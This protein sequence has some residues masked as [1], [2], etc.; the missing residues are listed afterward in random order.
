MIQFLVCESTETHLL[1]KELSQQS[2][3]VFIGSSF[4]RMVRM[5]EV[6]CYVGPP[7]NTSME[8]K[9]SPIVVGD[10]LFLV[11]WDVLKEFVC[12]VVYRV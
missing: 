6:D 8:S 12:F 4:P 9:F 5:S 3:G 2:V 7:F 11:L 10:G 1:W